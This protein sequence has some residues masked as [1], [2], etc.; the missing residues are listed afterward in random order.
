MTATVS[1]FFT[2]ESRCAIIMVVRPFASSSREDC[3]RCSVTVSSAEVAS[4][5]ISIC[6]FFRKTRA[7]DM[8]CFCPPDSIT[9]R[10]PIY[11]SYPSGMSIISLCISART[12]AS[13]ISSSV[14]SGRP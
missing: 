6:G 5:S 1:A 7:M 8:R 2:V 9:P 12:A 14:A 13:T 4:S 3:M 11:V 10:S